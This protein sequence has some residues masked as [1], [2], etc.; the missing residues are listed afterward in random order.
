MQTSGTGQRRVA[1]RGIR[2]RP[3]QAADEFSTEAGQNPFASL[4]CAREAFHRSL[5]EQYNSNILRCQG[6]MKKY[7]KGE[8]QTQNSKITMR[9]RNAPQKHETQSGVQRA[10]AADRQGPL[11][12]SVHLSFTSYPPTH[13]HTVALCLSYHRPYPPASHT[14]PH[15]KTQIKKSVALQRYKKRSD[16][17]YLHP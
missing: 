6:G 13:R 15:T 7:F 11:S 3:I 8:V 5:H 10:A 9:P 17:Q 14:S 2:K 1:R 12:P 16:Q 4:A